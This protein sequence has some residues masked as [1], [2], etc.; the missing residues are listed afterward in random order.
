MHYTVQTFLSGIYMIE[1]E[2]STAYTASM[3]PKFLVEREKN[4]TIICT[5]FTLLA[6]NKTILKSKNKQISRNDV[7]NGRQIQ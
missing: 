3:A 4:Y 1:Y 7:K 2:G 6:Q 5:A